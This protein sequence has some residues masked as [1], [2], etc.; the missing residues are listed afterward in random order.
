MKYWLF[1]HYWVS[2]IEPRRPYLPGYSD[3]CAARKFEEYVV[4]AHSKEAAMR[5]KPENRQDWEVSYV[6]EMP[7]LGRRLWRGAKK[8]F[9]FV[10]LRK[11]ENS[12]PTA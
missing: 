8:F 4:W 5:K 9:S 3:P 1:T 11:N 12:G 2:L 10:F 6:T 7:G